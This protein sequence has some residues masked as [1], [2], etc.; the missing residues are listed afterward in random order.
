MAGT[1]SPH[2]VPVAGARLRVEVFAL[3]AWAL[4]APAGVL[5]DAVVEPLSSTG[6][7]DSVGVR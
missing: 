6:W 3:V 1:D 5:L 7:S 2:P 4:R